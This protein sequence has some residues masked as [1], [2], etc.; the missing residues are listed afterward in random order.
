[1]DGSHVFYH[2]LP[3]GAGLKY[4]QLQGLGFIPLMLLMWVFPGALQVLLWPAY[5]LMGVGLLLVRGFAVSPGA[6]PT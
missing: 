4:R 1:L 2:L 5:R 3:P 6:F